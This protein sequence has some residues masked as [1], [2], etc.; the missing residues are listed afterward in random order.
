M[1]IGA[2]L[3]KRRMEKGL[4]LEA[5]ALEAGTDPGTLSRIERDAQQPSA[6]LLKKVAQALGVPVTTLYAEL[7][8]RGVKEPSPEYSRGIQQLQRKFLDLTPGNQKL[9]LEFVKML[10]KMQK[11]D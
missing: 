3:K 9:A 1:T 5:V 2:L 4:T 6:T 11:E 7:E 10:G 8:S